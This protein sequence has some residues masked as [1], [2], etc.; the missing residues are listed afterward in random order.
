MLCPGNIAFVRFTAISNGL[1]PRPRDLLSRRRWIHQL[2]TRTHA[3][4]EALLAVL[5]IW[6]VT[7]FSSLLQPNKHLAN[8]NFL[9]GMD[10]VY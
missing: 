1:L 4:I 10:C 3:A 2:E 5:C 8:K 6:S 7:N 9:G